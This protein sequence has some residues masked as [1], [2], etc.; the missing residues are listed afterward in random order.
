VIVEC[1]HRFCLACVE[2]E[3]RATC[4]RCGFVSATLC[5]LVRDSRE[6]AE[7]RAA[8]GAMNTELSA[9][10]NNNMNK[11]FSARVNNNRTLAEFHAAI[12]TMDKEFNKEFSARV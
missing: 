4:P 5:K 3:Q 8:V 10:V 1:A 11:E 9:R 7:F 2:K 12:D 6:L